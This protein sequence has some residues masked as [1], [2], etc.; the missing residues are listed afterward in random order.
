MEGTAAV[1]IYR[2]DHLFSFPAWTAEYF[3]AVSYT[4]QQKYHLHCYD[5]KISIAR[6]QIHTFQKYSIQTI[7][8]RC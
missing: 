6:K 1:A 3:L 7:I 5:I 8:K 4:K 2:P